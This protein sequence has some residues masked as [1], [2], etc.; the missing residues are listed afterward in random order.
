[1]HIGFICHEY[2]PCNHGGIGSFTKD[3]AEALSEK[4]HNVTVIGYYT[5][6]VLQLD[7]STDETIN[8]VR[9]LRYPFIKKFSSIPLNTLYLRFNLYK[10]I[11]KLHR[12]NNFRII[13]SPGGSGWLPF[14]LPAQ[15][16]LVTRLH[17]GEV[18]TAFQLGRK[19]PKLIRL[20]EKK[21]LNQSDQ[22][23]S[24]SKYT[25][26]TINS[27]LQIRKKYEVIYNS[28]DD[29]IFKSYNHESKTEKGL[30]VFTGTIKK[31]K[32]VEELTQAINIVCSKNK[33][34]HFIFAGKI[35][36]YDNKKTYEEYLRGLLNKEHQNKVIFT[37]NQDRETQLL[38]LLKKS[39]I[40]CFPSYVESFSL[41][42]IEAMSLGKAVVYTK[43][44]SGPETIINGESGLLCDPKS[45]QDIAYKI[46]MLLEDDDLREKLGNNGKKR[47]IEKFTFKTWVNHNISSYEKTIKV[48]NDPYE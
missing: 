4:G 20:L 9:V 10:R 31:A 12:Q 3:L 8:G 45:P 41:A 34:A 37:G 35:T 11:K 17:G 30:I 40:C 27:L 33:V 7:Y 2:P 19:I 28:I 18:Y 13:E 48:K 16:P 1:M 46:L 32:G 44:T 5:N 14:G 23:I 15:I 21:Q 43:L 47:V 6:P 39:D 26:K 42:P 22:I 38:P 25:A 24:V 36:P 29:K